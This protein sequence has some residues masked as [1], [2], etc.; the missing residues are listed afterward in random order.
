MLMND[1]LGS[2]HW[3][4]GG[5]RSD[6]A[7]ASS[8]IPSASHFFTWSERSRQYLSNFLNGYTNKGRETASWWARAVDWADW[9]ALSK[10]TF[11]LECWIAPCPGTKYPSQDADWWHACLTRIDRFVVQLFFAPHGGRE[12]ILSLLRHRSLLWGHDLSGLCELSSSPALPVRVHNAV[13]LLTAQL[14]ADLKFCACFQTN[15]LRIIWKGGRRRKD[16]RDVWGK[17][18]DHVKGKEKSPKL[19]AGVFGNLWSGC[20]PTR[21]FWPRKWT[22]WPRDGTF[23]HFRM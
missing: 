23:G 9:D 20:V 8:G 3:L 13:S 22:S 2:A 18:S 14:T 19:S 21:V 17:H 15:V 6:R 7:Q 10:P 12:Q 1:L 11:C 5:P 4:Y 16:R